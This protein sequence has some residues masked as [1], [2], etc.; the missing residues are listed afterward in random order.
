[1]ATIYYFSSTGNS[2]YV[3]KRIAAALGAAVRPMFRHDAVCE[4]DVVGL[5]FPAFFWGLPKTVAEF[6]S[7][8]TFT[9]KAPYLFSIVTYGGS[10]AGINGEVDR[11][12]RKQGRR[13]SYANKIKCVENYLPGY[14][15]NDTPQLHASVDE[16][17]DRIIRDILARKTNFPGVYTPLNRLIYATYPPNGAKPCDRIFR[18]EGC[19]GCALCEKVCPRN[20]I[21][22]EAGRPA[23]QGDCELCLACMHACPQEAINWKKSGGKARYLNPYIK[24]E[25]LFR[26]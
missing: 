19:V 14:K 22:M 3:S 12:L 23:F 18:V 9:A 17:T 6:L 7:G 21:R 13:C 5:V 1:M 11:L 16:K 8:V 26:T 25:E 10:I 20:N 2:L 15:V 4:D 24:L